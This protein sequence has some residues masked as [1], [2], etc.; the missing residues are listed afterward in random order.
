MT[1]V[2]EI[3]K[4]IKLVDKIKADL[5]DRRFCVVNGGGVGEKSILLSSLTT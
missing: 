2:S 1:Q 4:S 3:I 5:N